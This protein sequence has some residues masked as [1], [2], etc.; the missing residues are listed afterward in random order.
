MG[1]ATE[2]LAVFNGEVTVTPSIIKRR[3]SHIGLAEAK[4]IKRHR[5][6]KSVPKSQTTHT[7]ASITGGCGPQFRDEL[8]K[9]DSF[10]LSCGQI[11]Q[12]GEL[13]SGLRN[14]TFTPPTY[15]MFI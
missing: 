8:S 7:K 6:K 5:A 1:R 10:S 14:T 11:R 12:K 2:G 4:R 3:C 13:S 15:Y 9:N